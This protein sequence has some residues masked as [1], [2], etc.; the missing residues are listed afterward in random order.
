MKLILFLLFLAQVQQIGTN[1]GNYQINI[2]VNS[3]DGISMPPAGGPDLI[4]SS[5]NQLPNSP[6]KLLPGITLGVISSDM[7]NWAI[8]LEGGGSLR[9]DRSTG[10]V[11][12]CSNSDLIG[13]CLKFF[14]AN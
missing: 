7:K 8:L 13:P 12:R 4:I 2:A 10:R 5:D 11:K 3:V 6:V 1:E 9:I 14:K